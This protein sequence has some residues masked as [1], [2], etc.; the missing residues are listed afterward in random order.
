MDV[1]KNSTQHIK[2]EEDIFTVKKEQQDTGISKKKRPLPGTAT[3]LEPTFDAKAG[4]AKITTQYAQTEAYGEINEINTD[5]IH[6]TIK[7]LENYVYNM[8]VEGEITNTLFI[9]CTRIIEAVNQWNN[10]L[11]QQQNNIKDVVLNAIIYNTELHDLYA[12]SMKKKNIG[13]GMRRDP[14]S[15]FNTVHTNVESIVTSNTN[16]AIKTTS[17]QTHE[18]DAANTADIAHMF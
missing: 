11:L 15:P 4:L 10:T 8:K 6:R 17:Q 3:P 7:E 9:H 13:G 2:K 16:N 14:A 12:E 1:E 18:P 5:N